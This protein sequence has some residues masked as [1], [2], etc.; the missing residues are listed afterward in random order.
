MTTTAHRGESPAKKV[1]RLKFWTAAISLPAGTAKSKYLVLPSSAAGDLS[2]L[3]TLGVPEECIYAIDID[4][5][6]LAATKRRYPH[7]HYTHAPFWEALEKF[8]EL[9]RGMRCAFIDLCGPMRSQIV[10]KVLTL[11]EHC[12]LLG[13]EFLCGRE[14]GADLAGIRGKAADPVIARINYLHSFDKRAQHFRCR[15]AF[16]YMS[17]SASHYGKHMVAVLGE[18][19]RKNFQYTMEEIT[20][21]W[22]ALRELLVEL[23]TQLGAGLYNVSPASIAALK[24]HETRGTYR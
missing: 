12:D 4:K 6:A 13:Y 20:T 5:H 16:H 11:G 8:P 22:R 1:T 19:T 9:R 7:A 14:R 15:K 10:K 21:D 18:L 24:A 23:P 2:T 3:T 17:H